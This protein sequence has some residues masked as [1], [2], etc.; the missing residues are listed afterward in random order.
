MSLQALAGIAFDR[1]H[2]ATP[3]KLAQQRQAAQIAEALRVAGHLDAQAGAP[4]APP[5]AT[6][7]GEDQSSAEKINSALEVLKRYI[8]TELLALYI[9]FVAV[10]EDHYKG[11]A[12]IY[13][14]WVYGA[15]VLATPLVIW[16][17]YVAKGIEAGVDTG[18]LGFPAAAAMLGTIA[19]GVWGAS[20]PSVF[21]GAQWWLGLL[22]L[23][24]SVFL[25]VIDTFL[26]K[27]SSA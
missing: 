11:S 4:V 19:F 15:F 21:V 17:L 27:A 8:P 14:P 9:P 24:S 5:P 23:S 13:L 6:T 7:S 25:P 10:L 22:A 16:A 26:H 18:K 1:R 3:T 2:P 12:D 20:V